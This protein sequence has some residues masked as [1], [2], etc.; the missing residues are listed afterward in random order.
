M[1]FG[2]VISISDMQTI[3][4]AWLNCSLNMDF[5]GSFFSLDLSVGMDIFNSL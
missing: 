4:T 3:L 2:L 1:I 5:L